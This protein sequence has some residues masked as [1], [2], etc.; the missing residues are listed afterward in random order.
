MEDLEKEF[1]AI[2]DGKTLDDVEVEKVEE[3][4]AEEK[5][6]E[7]VAD[8][9]DNE[10]KEEEEPEEEVKEEEVKEEVKEVDPA[11]ERIA[12][13][14][15]EKQAEAIE[16]AQIAK[17]IDNIVDYSDMKKDD[18]LFDLND[19]PD[20]KVGE[21]EK[22]TDLKKLFTEYPA[23]MEA[24]NIMVGSAVKKAGNQSTQSL[25]ADVAELRFKEEMENIAPG[26]YATVQSQEF[27]TWVGNQSE[28][29]KM[30]ATSGDRSDNKLVLDAFSNTQEKPA[31]PKKAE[32]KAEKPPKDTKKEDM[33][34][35]LGS[36]LKSSSTPKDQK[37]SVDDM[38]MDDLE[39]EWAEITDGKK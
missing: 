22:E 2:C 17:E 15:A 5:K 38:T 1:D 26:T 20:V 10:P 4:I 6:E 34:K 12:E 7:E 11:A 35:L 18:Q 27:R 16:E 29:M 24:V 39:K 28:G 37:K 31:T 36:N 13:L 3:E 33:D 21:G 19:L 14:L 9:E 30:L 32:K 23:V 25:K 8:K